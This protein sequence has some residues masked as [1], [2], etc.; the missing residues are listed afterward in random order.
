MDLQPTDLFIIHKHKRF[1]Q[2]LLVNNIRVQ[3][4]VSLYMIQ[5]L[6]IQQCTIHA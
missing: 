5:Q 2:A 4:V 6:T 1:K 3:C